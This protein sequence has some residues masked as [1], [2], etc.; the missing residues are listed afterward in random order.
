[1]TVTP[2]VT[3]A[4]V[5][6]TSTVTSVTYG[7]VRALLL[8]TNQYTGRAFTLVKPYMKYTCILPSR[9]TER[10][11]GGEEAVRRRRINRPGDLPCSFK[12]MLVFFLLVFC[13]CHEMLRRI[14]TDTKATL[15]VMSNK[16]LNEI[17]RN[18]TRAIK[19]TTDNKLTKPWIRIEINFTFKYIDSAQR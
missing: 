16:S 19:S 8:S 12:R 9:I 10:A 6:V 2:T 11:E 5:T 4:F 17:Y 7:K 18:Y 13:N 15:A 14:N 1:M 3:S